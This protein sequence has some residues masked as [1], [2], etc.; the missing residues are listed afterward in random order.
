[1]KKVFIKRPKKRNSFHRARRSSRNPGFLLTIIGWGYSRAKQ[2]CRLAW[3]FFFGHC[4]NIFRAKMAQPQEKMART[5]MGV[6]W[7]FLPKS[8]CTKNE[9]KTEKERRF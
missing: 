9:T 5:P 3:Q 8:E 1:M 7:Y 6:A 2:F 4:R